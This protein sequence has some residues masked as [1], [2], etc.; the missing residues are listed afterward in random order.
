MF[1][2]IKRSKFI[3]IH[4]FVMLFEVLWVLMLPVIKS[5]GVKH[6]EDDVLEVPDSVWDFERN[7]SILRPHLIRQAGTPPSKGCLNIKL[8]YN[9][10]WVQSSA[11]GNPTL[12][13]QRAREVFKEAEK[14]YNTKFSFSNR[15]GTAIKFNL[16]GGGNCWSFIILQKDY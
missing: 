3:L 2:T 16:V 10:G 7:E 1:T 12:G 14:I 15:L 9:N 11:R 5:R 8:I 13:M 4:K 6:D